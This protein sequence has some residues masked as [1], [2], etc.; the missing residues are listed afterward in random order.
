METCQTCNT[1]VETVMLA[2]HKEKGQM[3]V[4]QAC[5]SQ[6]YGENEVVSGS[7]CTSSSGCSGSCT[8]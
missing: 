4:C 5:W 2:N 7:T 1:S 6:L 8:R 3:W